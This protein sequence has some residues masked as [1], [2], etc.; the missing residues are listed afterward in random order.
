MVV[1]KQGMPCVR[2]HPQRASTQER[3]LDWAP[4]GRGLF[5]NTSTCAAQDV[6]AQYLE[7]LIVQML[8]LMRLAWP[9]SVSEGIHGP[10][11][12]N[13]RQPWI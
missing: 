5:S 11:T 4:V 12:H 7:P 1:V 10:M 9:A 6:H 13:E 2:H 3:C 8:L